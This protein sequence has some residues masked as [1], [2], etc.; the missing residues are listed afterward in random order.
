MVDLEKFLESDNPTRDLRTHIVKKYE[1][2]FLLKAN[3]W[4]TEYEFRWLV[5]S[6]KNSAEYVSSDGLIE[7]VL[8]GAD[9]P[10]AD[11]PSLVKMCQELKVPAG[12]MVWVNGVPYLEPEIIY[13]P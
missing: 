12:R 3:D 10:K 4:E 1:R 11:E 6:E 13:Q 5:Y 2:L 8:V 9:F 7:E